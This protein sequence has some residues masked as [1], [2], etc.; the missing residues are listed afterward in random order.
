MNFRPDTFGMEDK[1]QYAAPTRTNRT[2]VNDMFGLVS[3][4]GVERA[5]R[6]ARQDF[7]DE[8]ARQYEADVQEMARFVKAQASK[9]TRPTQQENQV[10]QAGTPAPSA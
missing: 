8:N 3:R 2:P 6:Q 7:Y 1:M 10:K 4:K 9:A 5:I